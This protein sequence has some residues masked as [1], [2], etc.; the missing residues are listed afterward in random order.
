MF[1]QLYNAISICE[2]SFSHLCTVALKSWVIT[3]L[4]C[5]VHHFPPLYFLKRD[6]IY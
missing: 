5:K 3:K 2:L 6:I 1:L 4:N